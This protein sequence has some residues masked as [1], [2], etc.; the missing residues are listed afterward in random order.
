MRST[1]FFC[2]NWPVHAT[3]QPA[4]SKGDQG[5]RIRLC[6]NG[7]AQ[8]FLEATRCVCCLPIKI[9]SSPGRLIS[10]ALCSSLR[11]TRDLAEPF[12]NFAANVAGGAFYAV[13]IHGRFLHSAVNLPRSTKV[14]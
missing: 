9:L 6:F 4:Y 14:P 11:A 2:S 5:A 1:P 8:Y 10:Q 13:L 7:P 12:L 3:K